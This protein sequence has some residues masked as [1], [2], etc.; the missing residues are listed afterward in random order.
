MKS[1]PNYTDTFAFQLLPVAFQK[2]W[3]SNK[4]LAELVKQRTLTVS[5][6]FIV[7]DLA[8]KK[9]LEKKSVEDLRLLY[10]NLFYGKYT[11]RLVETFP[12]NKN[13]ADLKAFNKEFKRYN[14]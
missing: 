8:T 6:G 11:R 14:K 10:E 12:S 5:K 1:F 2:R 13:V 9:K 3:I 7:N 4:I